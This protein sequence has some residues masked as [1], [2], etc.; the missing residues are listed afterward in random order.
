M[1]EAKVLL[2]SIFVMILSFFLLQ[3]VFANDLDYVSS[4]LWTGVLDVQVVGDYAYCA[5]INGLLIMDISDPANPSFVSQVYF[6]G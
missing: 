3:P 2:A 5:Y 1:R 4:I 6:Q